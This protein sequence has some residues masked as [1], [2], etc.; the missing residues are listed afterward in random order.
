[1]AYE[2]QAEGWPPV[3]LGVGGGFGLNKNGRAGCLFGALTPQ[4]VH[5]QAPNEVA[6]NGHQLKDTRDHSSGPSIPVPEKGT[7]MG[8]GAASDI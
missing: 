7:C 5:G 4:D 1:M 6:S 3:G 8:E 2:H